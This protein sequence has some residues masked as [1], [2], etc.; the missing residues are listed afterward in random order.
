MIKFFELGMLILFGISWPVSIYKSYKSR[1]VGSKSV[2]FLFAVMLGYLSGIINK[3]L[4]DLDYVTV[5]Y[6]INMLMVAVD[7]IL[8]F[9]NK[10]LEKQ[11]QK[12]IKI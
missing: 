7:A 1:V 4:N 5:F 6:F 2:I 12:N 11:E 9:R 10:K 8:Y 3:F